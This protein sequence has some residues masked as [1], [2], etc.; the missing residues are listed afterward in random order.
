MIRNRGFFLRRSTISKSWERESSTAMGPPRGPVAPPPTAAIAPLFHNVRGVVIRGISSRNSKM[1]HFQIHKATN[2]RVTNVNITA[3]AESPNT[4]GIHISNSW[5][6]QIRDSLIG[7]G[8]DCVSLGDG[9]KNVNI[10]G[11]TCG[12]GHGISIGSLGKYKGEE[13]VS[14]ITVTK[15]HL[16][17]TD[18]GL[19]IKTWAPS[20]SSTVVS[21]ITF[22]DITLTNV[23]NPIIIDQ[24]YYP[25][26]DCNSNGEQSSVQIMGVKY[27]NIRG[28]SASEKAINMQCSE[29]MPWEREISGEVV[30]SLPVILQLDPC[31]I[32]ERSEEASSEVAN[33]LRPYSNGE[34]ELVFLL[35]WSRQGPLQLTSKV[36][37]VLRGRCSL[38]FGPAAHSDDVDGKGMTSRCD[39]IRAKWSKVFGR[40]LVEVVVSHFGQKYPHT[41]ACALALRSALNAQV[42]ARR[43]PRTC[44]RAL[45]LRAGPAFW[46]HSVGHARVGSPAPVRALA[47]R[48]GLRAQ[49]HA[50][51]GNPAPTR[52]LALRSELRAQV[53]ARADFPAPARA[54]PPRSR[55]RAQV[56]RQS[57]TCARSGPALWT[58]S[59]EYYIVMKY[60]P[61]DLSKLLDGEREISGEVIHSLPVILQLHP[62]FIRERSEEALSEV[63]NDLRPY[64]NGEGPL[65]LTSKVSYVLHGR[66]SL[67][68]GSAAHSDDV[69]GKGMASRCDDIR[70]KW[71]KVFGRGLVDVVVRYEGLG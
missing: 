44:V 45:A 39:D 29:M 51:V 34:G 61:R 71:S 42:R 7:T 63:A 6:V 52:A 15:C 46:T 40:G 60:V 28:S 27:I 3:P 32:R 12:P 33:D 16:M 69:D 13:D 65:Q 57:R 8:D 47:L 54:L 11:V 67:K 22:S 37:C 59:V 10:T 31:F 58:Q 17:N 53:R 26:G 48:A 2:L 56:R 62:C 43:Q 9:S 20:Q 50:Q 19:R 68:F 5:N 55:L 36:S 30:H 25:D 66:C 49:I 24:H 21:N 14:G 23:M 64:S 70:A 4:D 38:K 35:F 41:Y 1:F 18:N